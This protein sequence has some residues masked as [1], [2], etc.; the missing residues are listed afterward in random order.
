MSLLRHKLFFA[1]FLLTIVILGGSLGYYLLALLA[2]RHPYW[3]LPT[4]C[5]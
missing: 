3:S 5:I 4:V 1:G 2:Y